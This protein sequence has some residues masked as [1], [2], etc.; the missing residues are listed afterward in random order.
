MFINHN[1]QYLTFMTAGVRDKPTI[2]IA[3]VGKY[4]GFYG[5]KNKIK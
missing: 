3:V 5:G 1:I 4:M 2:I